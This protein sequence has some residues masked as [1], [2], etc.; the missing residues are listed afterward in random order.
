M[1]TMRTGFQHTEES[2]T[3]ATQK[4]V[5]N[6]QLLN[7]SIAALI[8]NSLSPGRTSVVNKFNAMGMSGAVTFLTNGALYLGK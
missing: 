6:L 3:V 2:H 7:E 5:E 8:A 4:E 1:P